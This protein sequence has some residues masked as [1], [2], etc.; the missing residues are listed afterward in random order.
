[1]DYRN[2]VDDLN[3]KLQLSQLSEKKK[4]REI[5]QLKIRLNQMTIE[6]RNYKELYSTMENDYKEKYIYI[7]IIVILLLN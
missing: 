5:E 2:A 4:Q 6:T 1:M 7:Y 3:Q